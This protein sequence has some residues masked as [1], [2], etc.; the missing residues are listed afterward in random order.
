MGL[1]NVG[2][3]F[4]GRCPRLRV[5]CSIM[6]GSGLLDDL[7]DCVGDGRVSVVALASCGEGVFSHLFGPN[8]TEGVVFRSSAPLLMVC[9]EPG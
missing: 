7:S 9:K 2:R 1:T 3:C 8:V 5:R 6:G 4:R